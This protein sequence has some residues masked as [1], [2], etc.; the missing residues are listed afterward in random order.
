MSNHFLR[1]EIT[2]MSPADYHIRMPDRGTG[3]TIDVQM[4]V[5]ESSLFLNLYSRIQE[6]LAFERMNQI[7]PPPGQH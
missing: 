2:A 7:L 4:T 3:Q 1:F 6:R 5:T